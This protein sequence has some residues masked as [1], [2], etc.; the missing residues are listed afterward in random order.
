[1]VLLPGVKSVG[2]GDTGFSVRGGRADQ[3]LVLY[4]DAVIYNPSHPFGFFSA[5]NADMLKSAEL[6]KSTVSA[7]H[8][9]RLSSVL[10]VVTRDGN[11]KQFSGSGGIGLLTSRLTSEG[12]LAH[13]K[14][15]WLVGRRTYSD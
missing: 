1:M 5:F 6:Y 8:G 11:R 2:E 12:P 10:D 14:G 3:N 9:G 15:S 13:G 7:R 4:N